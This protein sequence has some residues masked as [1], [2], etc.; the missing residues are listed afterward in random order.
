MENKRPSESGSAPFP[1]DTGRFTEIQN[2][3]ERSPMKK[4]IAVLLCVLLWVSL[5]GCGSGNSAPAPTQAPA[6]SPTEE[7]ATVSTPT[8]AKS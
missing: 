7:S 4:S 3:K 6:A 1:P 8:P 5:A 2:E